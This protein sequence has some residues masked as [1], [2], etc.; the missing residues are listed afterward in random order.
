MTYESSLCVYEG[1]VFLRLLIFKKEGLVTPERREGEKG[2]LKN[3]LS[4]QGIEPP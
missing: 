2:I 1:E 4:V 3:N